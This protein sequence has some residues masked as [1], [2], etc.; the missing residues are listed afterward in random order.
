MRHHANH[1][2]KESSAWTMENGRAKSKVDLEL[3]TLPHVI[4][5]K[6]SLEHTPALQSFKP[7]K[8]DFALAGFGSMSRRR[9][10]K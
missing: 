9:P 6:Y 4:M 1:A 2:A 7:R 3:R 8:D 5:L 10:T